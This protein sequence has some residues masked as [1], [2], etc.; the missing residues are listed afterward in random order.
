MYHKH[1]VKCECKPPDLTPI[2]LLDAIAVLLKKSCRRCSQELTLHA[3]GHVG[4]RSV[5]SWTS[6]AT[7]ALDLYCPTPHQGFQMMLPGMELRMRVVQIVEVRQDLEEV[8][9]EPTEG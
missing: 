3:A 4:I 9:I 2:V 5:K 8:K 1:G 6:S 7:M